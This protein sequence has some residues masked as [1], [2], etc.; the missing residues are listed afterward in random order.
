MQTEQTEAPTADQP[1][2]D[3]PPAEAPAPEAPAADA[4]A[5]DA[6]PAGID[7]T[8]SDL[9]G[10]VRAAMDDP[11]AA[12]ELAVS[13]SGPLLSFAG[14]VFA[15]LL[16]LVIG[17]WIASRIRRLI[18]RGVERSSRFDPT[19]AAFFASLAYY[20]A[21]ALVLI[22]TLGV[23]GV[24]TTS[25]AALLGAAG[26]AIGLA[27][28]GTLGHIA[29][30]VMLLMFRPFRVG[31]YVLVAGLDGTV[32]AVT[33]FTTELA[34]VDN[35]KIILPNGE[36]WDSPITNFS[37]NPTRRLDMVLGIAYDAD[38]DQAFAAIRA[39]LEADERAR[40]EPEP[41]IAVDGWGDSSVDVTVRVWCAAGDYFPLKW[42][43]LKA[44]KERFDR[45]GIGIPFPCR[46]IYHAGPIALEGQTAT[47]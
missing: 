20:G 10:E 35:K 40:A 24:P 21:V 30:G 27:L 44:I 25:F 11:Q 18:E 17:L 22:T 8:A 34:T 28:Q 5:A 31:D 15:A 39:E 16:V 4:P 26:L 13:M 46:T 7:E 41:I 2:A 12:M 47:Q 23:F 6:P 33:L 42:A 14:R 19:I 9:I 32:R 43:L 45:E 29:S 37:A 36:V 38:I 3:Q 1:A